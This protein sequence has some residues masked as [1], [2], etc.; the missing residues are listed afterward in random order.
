VAMICGDVLNFDVLSSKVILIMFS[1]QYFILN[2][3][4]SICLVIK[5]LI[6]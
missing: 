4:G 1:K 5:V 6:L 2:C 3:S